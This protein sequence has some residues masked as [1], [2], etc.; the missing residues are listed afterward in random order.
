MA[1]NIVDT[2]MIRNYTVA[3]FTNGQMVKFIKVN[4]ITIR[5][6]DLEFTSYKTVENM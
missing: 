5:K 6:K 4:T 1:E 2:G 3:V